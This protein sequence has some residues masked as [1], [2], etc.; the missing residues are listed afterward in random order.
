LFIGKI[1]AP[2]EEF[3]RVPFIQ[4]KDSYIGNVTCPRGEFSRMIFTEEM[5]YARKYGYS[6][7]I[8]IWISFWKRKQDSV[9][10]F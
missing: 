2:S 3:L 7:D 10:L 9:D 1:T 4:Y 5:K 8:G 6:I